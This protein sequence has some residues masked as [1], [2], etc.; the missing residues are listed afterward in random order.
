MEIDTELIVHVA[1]VARLKLSEEEI[2]EFLPQLKE[3]I[4]AFSELKEVDTD[5]IV[6][7]FQPVEMKDAMRE[8]RP[9]KSLKVEEALQ[10]A[11]STKDGYFK[12]PRVM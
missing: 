5:G 2:K 10:N 3:I 6:P 8:D 1:D 11:G 4:K 7:S 12:G 9:E